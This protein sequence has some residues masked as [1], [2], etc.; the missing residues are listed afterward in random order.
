MPQ[1]VVLTETIDFEVRV[2]HHESAVLGDLLSFYLFG[3][4]LVDHLFDLLLPPL[5]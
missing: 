2:V 5:G 1:H 4:L 3:P